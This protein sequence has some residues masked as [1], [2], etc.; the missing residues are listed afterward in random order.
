M[1]CNNLLI[2][3]DTTA[4]CQLPYVEETAGVLNYYTHNI[5]RL[6]A[7]P[8]YVSSNA[9]TVVYQPAAIS[10]QG[11]SGSSASRA[12]I[13]LSVVFTVVG[14]AVL[15]GVV[16]RLYSRRRAAQKEMGFESEGRL[17]SQSVTHHHLVELS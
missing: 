8:G 13:A 2:F 4:Q 9:V 3:N 7:M 15:A 16:W 12:T 5:I 10:T 1:P 14:L 6:M 11:M 17:S